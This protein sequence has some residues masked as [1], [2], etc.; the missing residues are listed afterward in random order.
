MSCG[1][2]LDF[3]RSEDLRKCWADGEEYSCDDN[4]FSEYCT[5]QINE[6]RCPRFWTTEARDFLAKKG[7]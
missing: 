5:K 3:Q 7:A 6:H 1:G 4:V 2:Y